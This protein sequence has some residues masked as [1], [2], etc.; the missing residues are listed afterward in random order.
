L[1]YQ[2]LLYHQKGK[3]VSPQTNLAAWIPSVAKNRKYQYVG[4]LG[5]Q[6]L[7][8]KEWKKDTFLEKIRKNRRENSPPR[9]PS[10]TIESLLYS[11]FTKL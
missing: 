6:E 7:N 11:V 2:H 10:F 1:L 3:D 9:V 4:M 5:T 8:S